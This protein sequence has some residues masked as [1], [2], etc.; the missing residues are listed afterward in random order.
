MTAGPSPSPNGRPAPTEPGS[1]S[2]AM[3]LP[4]PKQSPRSWRE[5][6]ASLTEVDPVALSLVAI[7]MFRPPYVLTASKA[8]LPNARTR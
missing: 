3:N 7:M 6:L 2:S 5:Y 8:P 1:P 4:S